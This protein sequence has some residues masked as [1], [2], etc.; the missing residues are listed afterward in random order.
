MTALEAKIPYMLRFLG[1]EDDDVSEAV[2]E[3]ANEYIAMIKALP[4][5][6]QGQK[7][8]IEVCFSFFLEYFSPL[9]TSS[10]FY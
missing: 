7:K 2:M 5:M 1:D 6:S 3:F 9:H 10:L 4:S 8:H